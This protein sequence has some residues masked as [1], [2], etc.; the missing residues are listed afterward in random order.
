[1]SA[2]PSIPKSG[3]QAH[4]LRFASDVIGYDLALIASTALRGIGAGGHTNAGIGQTHRS[5]WAASVKET[6][7]G[8]IPI[9]KAC[10]V[11]AAV[12]RGA[13]FWQAHAACTTDS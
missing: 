10:L 5:K 6:R 11:D 7:L 12:H 9:R 2:H 13:A 8:T 1:M 3:V 4:A